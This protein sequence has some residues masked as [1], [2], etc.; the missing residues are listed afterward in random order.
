M[1]GQLIQWMG[2]T[3]GVALEAYTAKELD[4]SLGETLL[5]FKQ[6]NGWV[7]CARLSGAEESWVPLNNVRPAC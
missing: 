7:W 1:P 4:V 6:L 2:Q 5:G 3:S